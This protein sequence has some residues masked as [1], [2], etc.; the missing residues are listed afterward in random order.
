MD[1]NREIARKRLQ[2]SYQQQKQ[3]RLKKIKSKTYRKILKK[4][5]QREADAQEEELAKLDPEEAQAKVLERVTQLGIQ[6]C[7]LTIISRKKTISKK[8][9]R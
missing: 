7:N 2:L 1:R 5:K 8:E 6:F 4:Q 3:A 9:S